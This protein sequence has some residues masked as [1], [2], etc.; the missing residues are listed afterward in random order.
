M[1]RQNNEFINVKNQS[2]TRRESP[3]WV[4]ERQC[5]V[6]LLQARTLVRELIEEKL[7][8]DRLL[9]GILLLLKLRE[10]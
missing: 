10:F 1:R 8:A 4:K 7:R 6:Y 5:L 9:S 2:A 3:L